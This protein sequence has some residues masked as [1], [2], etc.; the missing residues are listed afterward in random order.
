MIDTELLSDMAIFAAVVDHDGFSK[1]ADALNMS[2]SS[3]SRRVAALEKR[4]S[5][6]L[7]QRTTR[8]S[9]LTESGRLYYDYCAQLVSNAEE[10]DAAVKLMQSGMIDVKPL[11]THSLDMNDAVKAFELAA[12]RSQAMKVQL[13]F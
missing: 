4:L 12:D 2:K 9:T 13:T 7:M 8:S 3:V 6:K 5:I 1:A 11:I 10:A